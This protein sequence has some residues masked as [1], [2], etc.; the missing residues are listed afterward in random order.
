MKI[1][2]NEFAVEELN[3][4]IDYYD[5]ELPGLGNLFKEELQKS[6]HRIVEYP[7]SEINIFKSQTSD[8]I[9]HIKYNKKALKLNPGLL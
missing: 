7:T 6:L 8:L 2:F 9:F 3:D 1:V 4:A 5:L